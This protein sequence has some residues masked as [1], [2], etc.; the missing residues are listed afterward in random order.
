MAVGRTEGGAMNPH[1][2]KFYI[3]GA[4]VVPKQS[5]FCDVVNPANEDVAGQISFGTKADVD[6]AVAAV[7]IVLILGG[8]K[9]RA[10][11]KY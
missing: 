3:D 4:W 1:N 7:M 11:F 10:I 2:T 5:G 9:K 6:D 8:G